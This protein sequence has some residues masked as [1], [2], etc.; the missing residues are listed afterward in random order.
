MSYSPLTYGKRVLVPGPRQMAPK[1]IPA[2]RQAFPEILSGQ[3]CEP[4][5]LKI[6]ERLRLLIPVA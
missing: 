2:V 5:F 1:P 3:L 4:S 6:L